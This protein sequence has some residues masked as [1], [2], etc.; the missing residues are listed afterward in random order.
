M[1]TSKKRTVNKNNRSRVDFSR[2]LVKKRFSAPAG[3]HRAF[4]Q[5]AA[6]GSLQTTLIEGLGDNE[7]NTIELAACVVEVNGRSRAADILITDD[8]VLDILL[9]CPENHPVWVVVTKGKGKNAGKT[10]ASFANLD[11]TEDAND[12]FGVWTPA[13]EKQ[14]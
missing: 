1:A 4:L 10:Y 6:D 14:A 2:T 9:D 3:F 8:E 11:E 5:L 12:E 13:Q 7:D